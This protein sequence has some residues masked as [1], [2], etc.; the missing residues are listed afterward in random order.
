MITPEPVDLETVRVDQ[1]LRCQ[2]LVAEAMALLAKL[3]NN[4]E[5]VRAM[6]EAGQKFSPSDASPPAGKLIG[7]REQTPQT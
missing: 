4:E 6:I 1:E 3:A 5:A 2:S 7:F